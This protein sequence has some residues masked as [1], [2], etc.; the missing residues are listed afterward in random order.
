MKN[1]HSKTE[2]LPHLNTIA[3]ESFLVSTLQL[4]GLEVTYLEQQT[5]NI[6]SLHYV[7][8]CITNYMLLT[9][10]TCLSDCPVTQ[11]SVSLKFVEDNSKTGRL[12]KILIYSN[13]K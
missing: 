1:I 8:Y 4:L 9:F 6:N 7:F 2:S 13:T 12:S 11:L 3:F 5:H 10:Y